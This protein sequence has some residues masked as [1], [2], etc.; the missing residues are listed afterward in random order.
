VKFMEHFAYISTAIYTNGLWDDDDGFFYDV[1]AAD[2]GRRFPLKVRSMVGLLPVCAS[3]TLGEATLRRLPEFAAR[4]SWFVEHRARYA[5]GLTAAHVRAGQPG[6]LFTMVTPKQLPRILSIMLDEA[7]FLSPYGLRSLSAAH[8]DHP[9]VLD[10]DGTRRSVDYEPAE[11]RTT[12]YGGNSNWRGPVW[13]PVNHL[14]VQALRRFARFYGDDFVIEHPHGS[15]TQCTLT[16]VADE[17]TR[18]LVRLFPPDR[19]GNVTFYEYFHGDTGKGLGASHQTGWSGLVADLLL[20]RD[21]S[22]DGGRSVG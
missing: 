16:E 1:L 12:L 4:M 22:V 11:S 10:V 19:F 13:M 15:G 8:R 5:G 3:M 7:E 20:R 6:R 14:V 2:D 17:L 21:I 9:F 18:R